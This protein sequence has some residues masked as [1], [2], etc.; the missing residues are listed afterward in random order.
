MDLIVAM[1]IINNQQEITLG[2]KR[3][4]DII[5]IKITPGFKLNT[6]YQ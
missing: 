4:K 2:V 6:D 5:A 3:D 1:S